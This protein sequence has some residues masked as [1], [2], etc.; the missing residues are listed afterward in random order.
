MSTEL[1]DQH[2]VMAA[3]MVL[4]QTVP[5]EHP[6]ISEGTAQIWYAALAAYSTNVV[7]T[8]AME[9]AGTRYPSRQEFVEAVRMTRRVQREGQAALA[10]TGIEP[11]QRCPE[12][13]GAGWKLV[14]QA[15]WT[16]I[17]CPAGCLPPLPARQRA[18]VAYKARSERAKGDPQRPA[19]TGEVIEATH[20]IQGERDF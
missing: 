15:P 10:L 6:E 11:G 9:W 1:I 18:L 7:M 20:R 8:A 5:G 3:M 12:C 16:V 4:R 14:S 13:D 19:V 2:G 17:A